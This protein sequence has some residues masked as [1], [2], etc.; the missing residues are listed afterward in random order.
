MGLLQDVMS[1]PVSDLPL[2]QP[3]LVPTTYSVRMVV[4]EM[5]KARLGCAYI[6]DE[7][8]HP[9]GQFTERKLVRLLALNPSAMEQIITAHMDA[10]AG[11]VALRDPVAKVLALMERAGLRF[12]CVKN[13]LGQVVGLTGQKSVMEF[14]ADHLPDVVVRGRVESDRPLMTREG[15]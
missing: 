11:V 1:Q 6:V 9:I 5:K 4:V 10:V 14:I 12:V 15:A 13:R 7:A 2:R 3:V 8:G